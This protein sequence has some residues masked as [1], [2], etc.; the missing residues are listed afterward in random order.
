MRIFSSVDCLNLWE[1]GAGLHPLDQGLL[2]LSAALPEIP[3]ETLA[4]WPLGRRNAALAQ[5]RSSSFGPRLQGR[6][7]CRRCGEKL[8]V[9]FDGRVLATAG[10]HQ[11]EGSAE[12]VLVNGR[13]F[14]LPTTRD[15]AKAAEEADTRLAAIRLVES[16]LVES[17]LAQNGEPHSW[18][19]D[20]LEQIGQE[21]AAADPLAETLLVM[22]CPNCESES[23]E[24]LDIVTFLWR[25]IEARA[26]RLLL[27]I[28]TLAFAYGWDEADILSLSPRRRAFYVEMAQ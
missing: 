11:G 22:R 24:T 25:E 16:C 26:R 15:L 27:D 2:A 7:A 4:D 14:R 20:E 18:S 9:E 3:Q 21:M 12:T 23:E 10:A 5:L 8:E 6:T 1:S 17:C 19:D 13:A 28:H